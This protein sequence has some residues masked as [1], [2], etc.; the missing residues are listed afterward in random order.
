MKNASIHDEVPLVAVEPQVPVEV[1]PNGKAG[2][3][4]GRMGHDD[5]Q[6]GATGTTPV[7][8]PGPAREHLHDAVGQVLCAVP[9]KLAHDAAQ[10]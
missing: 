8:L 2:D 4:S 6:R 10:G 1:H 7:E 3:K 5:R 9:R